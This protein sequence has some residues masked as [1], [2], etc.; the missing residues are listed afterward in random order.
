[1]SELTTIMNRNPQADREIN[2]KATFNRV[3]ELKTT[4]LGVESPHMR[5]GRRGGS[6]PNLVLTTPAASIPSIPSIAGVQAPKAVKPQFT[7]GPKVINDPILTVE[8]ARSI[9]LPATLNPDTVLPA[10]TPSKGVTPLAEG[11]MIANKQDSILAAARNINLKRLNSTKIKGGD[12]YSR[13]ELASILR[14]LQISSTRGNKEELRNKIKEE[15]RRLG[16]PSE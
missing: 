12:T 5:M 16:L 1:M 4:P 2:E 15:L 14:D 3:P 11:K 13:E 7:F 10:P 8:L 6:R 9:A